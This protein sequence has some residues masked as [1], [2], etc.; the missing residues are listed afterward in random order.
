MKLSI[1][2]NGKIFCVYKLEELGIN[3]IKV[4]HITQS[5][6]DAIPIKIPSI[7][8]KTKQTILTFTGTTKF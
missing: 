4:V 7:F 3:I 1:Y 5:V 2:S 6:D 8:Q